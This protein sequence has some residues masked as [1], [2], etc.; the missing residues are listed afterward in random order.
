MVDAAS[1]TAKGKGSFKRKTA[2][3]ILG[4]S[5]CY[6]VAHSLYVLCLASKTYAEL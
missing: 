5:Q 6:W 2:E 4:K 1:N 3:K